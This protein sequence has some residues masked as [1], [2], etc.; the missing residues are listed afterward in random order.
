MASFSPSARVLLAE[1][2]FY[3]TETMASARDDER[4]RSGGA[5]P[6]TTTHTMGGFARRLAVSCHPMSRR[7]SSHIAHPEALARADRLFRMSF[8][9]L[10]ETQNSLSA[11]SILAGGT[12]ITMLT[13]EWTNNPIRVAAA[14]HAR[15][16]AYA[17]WAD[18]AASLGVLTRDRLRGD[19]MGL[20]LAG[21]AAEVQAQA[22]EYGLTPAEVAEAAR[23]TAGYFSAMASEAT[24]EGLGIVSDV[25]GRG[26]GLG[27]NLAWG[28]AEVQAQALEYDLTPAEVAEAARGTIAFFS[29]VRTEGVGIVSE[30]TGRGDGL[31]MAL[32]GGVAEVQA[33]AQDYGLTPAEVCGAA[34]GTNAFFHQPAATIAAALANRG[35]TNCNKATTSRN[36]DAVR[37]GEQVG[38][39]VMGPDRWKKYITTSAKQMNAA[40]KPAPGLIAQQWASERPADERKGWVF[41]HITMTASRWTMTDQITY[42]LPGSTKENPLTHVESLREAISEAYR[43]NW[44]RHSKAQNKDQKD[45]DA[46]M[47]LSRSSWKPNKKK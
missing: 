26:D 6:K 1:T 34:H 11:L 37:L 3:L 25:T 17:L 45:K 20:F 44:T 21:G 16:V 9:L 35:K 12:A 47:K 23:G 13:D 14:A 36:P 41:H 31:A 22:Q 29:E 10:Q 30:F 4:V 33:Q 46:G 19:A 32:A 40:D 24:A 38:L 18:Q 42:T 5:N 43:L 8:E 39:E 2:A 27:M 7:R 28:A 15:R